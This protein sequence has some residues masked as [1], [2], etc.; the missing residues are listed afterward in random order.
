MDF[1]MIVS[2]HRIKKAYE[3]GEFKALPGFGKPLNLDDDLGVPEELKMAHRMMK[4]AGFSTD[5][6]NVKKEMMRIEDLIKV[7]DNELDKQELQQNLNEKML[8]YNAMLSKKRINTNSS[9]FKN[10][11]HKLEGKLLK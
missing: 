9:L 10:Y 7:C 11:E 4:N 5:E 1:S 3:D 2:E 6:M 8:K